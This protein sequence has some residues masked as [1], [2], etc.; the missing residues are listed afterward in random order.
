[1]DELYPPQAYGERRIAARDAALD[2]AL[3][4]GTEPPGGVPL[5]GDGLVYGEFDATFFARLL[6]AA[7]PRQ[8]DIFVDVGSGVGRLILT[9]ALLWPSAWANCHGIELLPELHGAA[10]DA[11]V[12]FDALPSPLSTLPIAPVEYSAIDVYSASGGATLREAD[13]VF[14][15]AVTWARDAQGRLT[16]LSH[17]LARSGIKQDARIITVGV[18]LLPEASGVRFER[19]RSLQGDNEETGPDSLGHIF[20]VVRDT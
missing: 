9:A 7:Q 18:T 8:G 20:R 14:V 10:I 5:A 12:R 11:R 15:Y 13:V 3:S 6:A 16:E 2:H 17:A 19:V 4:S 1:V